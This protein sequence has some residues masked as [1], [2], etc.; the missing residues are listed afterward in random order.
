VRLVLQ[1]V[2][3]VPVVVTTKNEEKNIENY[4]RSIKQQNYLQDRIAIPPLR[5][6]QKELYHYILRNLI[7]K[8]MVEDNLRR[9]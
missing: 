6:I 7:I 1:N 3:D 2:I 8:M 9:I 4:L 5:H